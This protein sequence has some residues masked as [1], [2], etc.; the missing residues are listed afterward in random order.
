ME[1][2]ESPCTNC[3][4]H[5]HITLMNEADQVSKKHFCKYFNIE[6]PLVLDGDE[7]KPA[8]IVCRHGD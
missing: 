6:L 5:K 3:S 7:L 1:K 8:V 2:K 4:F